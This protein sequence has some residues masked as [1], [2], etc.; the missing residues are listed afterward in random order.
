MRSLALA[1]LVLA[2]L[3]TA[4]VAAEPGQYRKV[5]GL[6]L[7]LGV[8]P[9]ELVRG[10]GSKDEAMHGATPRG[11][12][13]YHIVVAVFDAA[14]GQRVTDA[15]VTARVSGL[16]LAGRE[17]PLQKMEIADTVSFGNYFD[18]SGGGGPYRI[19]V[20]VR[21]PGAKVVST[22]FQYEHSLR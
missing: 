20:R 12:H 14:S 13:L 4:S 11:K 15:E 5:D 7:Y 3:A 21:R 22:D 1:T 9:A 19:D 16:G 8:L 10:H 17:K 2:T 6:A 18:L